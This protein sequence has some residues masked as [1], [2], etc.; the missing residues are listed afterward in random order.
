M[1]E[2]TSGA[3]AGQGTEM[4][5]PIIKRTVLLTASS[6]L[7]LGLAGCGAPVHR[8]SVDLLEAEPT[9]E[10]FVDLQSRPLRRSGSISL[11]I[12]RSS[13]TYDSGDGVAFVALLE[14]PDEPSYDVTVASYCRC[15]SF[16]K[17]IL[18]P[19]VLVLD[20]NGDVIAEPG[21]FVAKAPTLDEPYRFGGS[22]PVDSRRDGA[23]YL[24][25]YAAPWDLGET[26]G[27]VAGGAIA[28]GGVVVRGGSYPVES[29]P[30]GDLRITVRPRR[31]SSDP[32]GRD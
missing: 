20:E 10:R 7:L 17:Q 30:F 5:H 23:R 1:G 6:L 13:P 18:D 16:R 32:G 24:L 29:S 31:G 27:A 21:P 26:A 8:I 14:L 25:I 9:A 15:L 19:T 22:F 3:R 11:A 28:A 2:P 4:L 12:G